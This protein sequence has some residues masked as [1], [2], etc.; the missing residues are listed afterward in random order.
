MLLKFIIIIGVIAA[1]YFFFIKKKP[2]SGNSSK[3]SIEESNDMVACHTCGTYTTIED[4][5]LSSGKYY[6][7]KKCLEKLK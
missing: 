5:L 2:L 1:V 7:S 4:S 6:C 3:N